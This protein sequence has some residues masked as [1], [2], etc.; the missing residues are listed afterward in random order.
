MTFLDMFDSVNTSSV[1]FKQFFTV[2][3]TLI[4]EKRTLCKASLSV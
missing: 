4:W 3:A 1:N 2:F